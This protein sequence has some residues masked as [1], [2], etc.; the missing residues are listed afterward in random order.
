MGNTLN[1][2]GR[3]QNPSSWSISQAVCL[4]RCAV[5]SSSPEMGGMQGQGT[6]ART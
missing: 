1:K 3:L 6:K 2:K 4:V 5:E